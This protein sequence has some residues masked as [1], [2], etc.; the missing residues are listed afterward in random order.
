MQFGEPG[1][2]WALFADDSANLVVW[3]QPSNGPEQTDAVF[4]AVIRDEI[5]ANYGVS[6]EVLGRTESGTRANAE[7]ATATTDPMVATQSA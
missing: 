4:F 6:L 5:L 1:D 2:Q 7:A 3:L